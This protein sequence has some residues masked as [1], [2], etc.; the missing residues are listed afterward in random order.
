MKS[1][2]Q[3]K[4]VAIGG[5]E[6]GRPKEDGS[7]NYPVET[8]PIDKEILHMT[9][10]LNA[11]LLFIPT[12]SND[13][14]NY[15]ELAKQH[16]LKI[17]FTAVNILYLSDKSLN[18][19]RIKETIL[20]HDA[21]YIGGGNTLKMMITWRRLGVDH[22]LK[23]A[24]DRGI[25]LSGISAGSICWFTYGISDGRKF[26]DNAEKLIKVKGLGFIEAL[27]SPHFDVEP[28]RKPHTKSKLKNTNN[29]AICLDNC[30]AL[31]IRGNNYRILRSK[32]TAKAHKAYWKNGEYFL[33]EIQNIDSF[34]NL[35]SLLQY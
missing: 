10:K 8:I 16:F 6:I 34:E 27:H 33:D 26:R 24:L 3:H 15:S 19:K 9:G 30:S 7:R 31:Q 21:I 11:T 29:V 12:A 5:G 23:L 4:I 13:S 14:Q 22:I 28:N 1:N 20:S 17:G 2:V 25:V 18:K 35:D 32:P